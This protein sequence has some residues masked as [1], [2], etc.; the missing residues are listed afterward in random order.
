MLI[1]STVDTFRSSSPKCFIAP[2]KTPPPTRNCCSAVTSLDWFQAKALTTSEIEGRFWNVRCNRNGQ[3][4]IAAAYFP[5]TP[6]SFQEIQKTFE[7]DLAGVA[8]NGAPTLTDRVKELK[9]F[10]AIGRSRKSEVLAAQAQQAQD[11]ADL[12][13]SR[14]QERET[15][16]PHLIAS[17]GFYASGG[18]ERPSGA[19]AGDS[20]CGNETREKGS[21][22][23]YE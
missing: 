20:M 2:T 22:S 10:E 5:P 11:A 21:S 12:E 19:F 6:P 4:W 16:I 9:N 1:A 8:A 23:L 18:Y 17:R 7:H 15:S 13:T 14:G 3:V